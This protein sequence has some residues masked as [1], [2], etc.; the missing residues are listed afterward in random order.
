MLRVAYFFILSTP[1]IGAAAPT[2]Q[3]MEGKIVVTGVTS[4]KGLSVVVAEGAEEDIAAR[5]AMAG[6]WATEKDRITFTPKYPLKPGTKYRVQG[7]DKAR[8][9]IVPQAES[10]KQT[11]VTRIDPTTSELP[12]NIL[13]FYVE[14]NQPMPRGDVYD[15][16]DI[17]TEKGKKI[18]WPFV[19]LTEELW[20]TDQTRLTLLIDPGRI[21]KEVKPRIDLGPVFV[22]GH[23]FTLVVSGKWPTLEGGTLGADVRKT[24]TIKPPVD[25]AIELKNWK[26]SPP[27]DAAAALNVTF[28]RLMDHHLLMRTLSVID[29]DGR[30]VKGKAESKN[31]DHDWTFRPQENWKSAKYNLRAETVLEDVCGNRIGM[32]FEVDL[33]KAA[34][35]E[36]KAK[37]VDI[38]FTVGR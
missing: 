21:K 20:N 30:E 36:V 26:L 34:P 24:I 14:F 6:E 31:D 35:K 5:P 19:R 4:A 13:R 32:P 28:D 23:K 38:P 15:F 1:L 10:R 7:L 9:V 12:E 11:V 2:A 27:T 8:T 17:Y 29:A 16:V 22:N 3:V 25:E 33:L 18:E 37:F